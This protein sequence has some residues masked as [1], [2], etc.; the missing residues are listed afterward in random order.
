MKALSTDQALEAAYTGSL[1]GY[2]NTNFYDL[3]EAIGEPSFNWSNRGDKINYEWAVN[4]RGNIFYIYDWKASPS[5][6]KDDRNFRF[7]IGGQVD[8]SAFIQ[9]LNLRLELLQ[10]DQDAKVIS[11]KLRANLTEVEDS[12]YRRVL[13]HTKLRATEIRRELENA[14]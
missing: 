9:A 2:I 3:V 4:Y 7:H 1:K 12:L 13:A 8:A 10:L 14:L 11:D 6:C 5:A